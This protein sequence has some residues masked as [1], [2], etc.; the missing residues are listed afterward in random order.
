MRLVVL[1]LSFATLSACANPPPSFGDRLVSEGTEVG[2]LGEQWNRG[3][4][5]VERGERLIT[6][7]ERDI[8]RGRDKVAEGHDMVN[9]GMRLMRESERLYRTGQAPAGG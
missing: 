6:E 4:D 1:L 9:R 8:D 5:L 7:G 3:T 2:Q